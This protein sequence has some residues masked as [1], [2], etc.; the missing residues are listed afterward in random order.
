[1]KFQISREPFRVSTRIIKGSAMKPIALGLTASLA[2]LLAAAA[3]SKIA[4]PPQV[5]F[6][7]DVAPILVKNCQGC[8]RPGETAP[9][10]LL[11]Y[12]QARP[13]AKAIREAVVLRR[14]P[15]W[16]ADSHFGKFSNDRSLAQSEIDTLV[17]W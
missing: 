4:K 17:A 3:P 7:K 2:T 15:P 14:M 8:H 12:Q 10:S 5:T 13:W 16:Y 11:M 1:M 9:M 6:S